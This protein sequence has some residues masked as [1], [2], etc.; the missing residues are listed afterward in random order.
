MLRGNYPSN[1]LSRGKSFGA[2]KIHSKMS[3]TYFSVSS[4]Q[5]SINYLRNFL[6]Y[7]KVES[8]SYPDIRPFSTESYI[9]DLVAISKV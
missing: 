8:T 1:F 3:A 6:C 4:A 2:N 9:F 5:P 7:M